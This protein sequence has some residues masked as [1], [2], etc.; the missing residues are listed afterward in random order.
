MSTRLCHKH[1]FGA[2]QSSSRG[3]AL[4]LPLFFQCQLMLE[5]GYELVDKSED[6]VSG[7]LLAAVALR[8]P[9]NLLFAAPGGH[10][11]LLCCAKM[12]L[13]SFWRQGCEM[14]I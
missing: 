11:S 8:T 5:A 9:C 7:M 13:I 10:T 12:L 3:V 14:E 4:T 6:T 2:L 1:V